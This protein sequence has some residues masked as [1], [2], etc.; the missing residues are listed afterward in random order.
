MRHC[1]AAPKRKGGTR[2]SEKHDC[3][4]EL[5]RFLDLDTNKISDG[6]HTFGELYDHRIILYLCLLAYIQQDNRFITWYSGTHNDDSQWGGWIVVGVINRDTKEQISYHIP[7]EYSDAL[8][9]LR[10]QNLEK[11]PKWDGHT[12]NDVLKRL[13]DWFLTKL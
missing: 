6:Y 2:L 7:E 12:P 9:L 10:I 4:N 1:P 8:D 5:I 11:A 13:T 3:I